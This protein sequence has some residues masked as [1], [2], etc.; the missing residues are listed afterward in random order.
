[1]KV[2]IDWPPSTSHG[3]G[4][5]AVNLILQWSKDPEIEMAFPDGEL[6]VDPLRWHAICRPV[7]WQRKDADVW[8]HGLGN[9]FH[10][11]PDT[12]RDRTIGVVFFEEQPDAEAIWR[13]KRYPLI[14][15]GSTWNERVLRDAGV[16]RVRTIFQGVDRTLFHPAPRL[17]LFGDRFAVF[18]GGKAEYRKGQD[19]VLAAFKRFAVEHRNALL[20]TAWHNQ[21]PYLIRSL[22]KSGLCTPVPMPFSPKQWAADNGINPD[23]V[24][25]IGQVQNTLMPT[26]YRECDCA[27]FPNRCEGGTNLVAMEAMACGLPT[28]VSSGHGHDDLQGPD[29]IGPNDPVDETLLVMNMFREMGFVYRDDGLFGF[30]WSDA[31]RKLKEACRE[32]LSCA[33]TL[34]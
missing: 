27:V 3:W 9:G 20:V 33:T 24:I 2:Y 8:L 18:S 28:A 14:I 4:I 11:E 5:Y 23:Q 12:P 16:S 17:G 26:I 34:A 21:W 30:Q 19:I 13:A 1:M 22:D 7:T 32:V 31:A 29:W 15:T 25:D 10:Y 6:I